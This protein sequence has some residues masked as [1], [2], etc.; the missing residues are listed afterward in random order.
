M[1]VGERMAGKIFVNY[2]RGDT[3]DASAR[4]RDKLAATFGEAH[5]F[6]DVDNLRPGERFDLKL[7]E[8][9]AGAD[10]FL[11]VIGARWMELLDSRAA[12]GERD[13]VCEEIAAALAAKIVV[14]PV[15]MD[16]APMPKA[17][18]LP[19]DI[20][21]LVL[22]HKHD[23]AYES[24]GRDVAVLVEAI[25]AHRR[26][27]A[28]Q[29]ARLDAERLTREKAEAEAARRASERQNQEA[30]T[31]RLA[32]EREAAEEAR[33]AKEKERAE[34]E[35][36]RRASQA[37]AADREPAGAPWKLIAAGVAV[38]AAIALAIS[39]YRPQELEP[40]AVRTLPAVSERTLPA[41][42]AAQRVEL[43]PGQSFKDCA[44]CPEMVVVPAGSFTMGSPDSE[45]DH[46]SDESPQH[47]VTFAKPFAVGRFAVTFAEWD[48]C[49]DAGGCGGYRPSDISW[50]RGRGDR[51]VID[52]SWD[53]AKA[54]VKWLS[55]K[56][57]EEY[58]L[59][60]EAE[61]EYVARAGTTTPFWWGSSISTRQANY[62]GRYTYSGGQTGEYR[63][64][65]LPVKSFEPNPWALYQVHG[66]I[67]EWVED[68]LNGNYHNAPSDGSAWTTG[69]CGRRI[70][71][72]GS[73]SSFP[74]NLRA[75]R[76]GSGT[77]DNRGNGFG[78]RVAAGWQDL[79]R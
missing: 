11:A 36:R 26:E 1:A 24:F 71:R 10:V 61:R 27:R 4:L 32:R 67:W 57:G 47:E 34:A 58:R 43:K 46:Q 35:A 69:N 76:R 9:L 28:E 73:W 16:R 66:N 23:V 54:Y 56:T 78:F 48:A 62:D 45:P 33:L 70:L 18:D 59:L 38:A 17:A 64:K 5:V 15:V 41:P 29:W 50:D 44:D 2:R 25:E 74:P 37:G 75:A 8:A 31:A 40:G 60:S 55:K 65:T 39:Y 30:E 72:G 42:P 13:F 7:Q 51:P 68:C 21:E 14:I 49:V 19:E 53:D 6:M 3:K 77:P 52:V 79:H 22:Y 20:R 63:Q 12:S